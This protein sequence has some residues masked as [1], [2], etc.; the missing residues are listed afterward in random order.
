MTTPD[1]TLVMNASFVGPAGVRKISLPIKLS[2]LLTEKLIELAAYPA[3][4]AVSVTLTGPLVPKLNF[5]VEL[6]KM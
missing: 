4:V 2:P 1:T 3:L 5:V 6:A